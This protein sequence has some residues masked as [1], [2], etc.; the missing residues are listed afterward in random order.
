[1][2][3]DVLV[4]LDLT[5]VDVGW[6]VS[7]VGVLLVDDFVDEVDLLVDEV[8]VDE[9]IVFKVV[10]EVDLVVED[11]VVVVA[12]VPF[13]FQLPKSASFSTVGSL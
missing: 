11:D 4:E 1:M 5:V 3:E 6:L 12:L 13:G 10:A 8:F 7:E 9:V 2:I